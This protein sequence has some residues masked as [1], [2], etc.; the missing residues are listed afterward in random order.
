MNEYLNNKLIWNDTPF[1]LYEKNNVRVL[2]SYLFCIVLHGNITFSSL[3]IPNFD[4]F[5]S[6]STG[7]D[8]PVSISKFISFQG[9][10]AQS[11]RT[12]LNGKGTPNLKCFFQ[13][14]PGTESV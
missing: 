5:V 9:A 11:D 2:Y 8:V 7:K 6:T 14:R 13:A 12:E 4:L 1:K 10:G 3:H